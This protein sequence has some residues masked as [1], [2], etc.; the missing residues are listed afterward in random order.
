MDD[1]ID[2]AHRLRLEQV[3]HQGQ[4]WVALQ[5]HSRQTREWH[6]FQIIHP[7]EASDAFGV[8][9]TETLDAGPQI[10]AIVPVEG[11]R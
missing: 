1:R 4:R 9:A 3:P 6:T 11:E 7:D 5:W 8:D 10:V 2:G